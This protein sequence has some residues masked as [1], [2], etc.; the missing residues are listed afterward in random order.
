MICLAMPLGSSFKARV[1]EPHFR[2]DGVAIIKM[3]EV[4]FI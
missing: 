2:E 4:I 3:E 1:V